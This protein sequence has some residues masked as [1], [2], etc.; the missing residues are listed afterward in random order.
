MA[1]HFSY[2]CPMCDNNV[3]PMLALITRP[4]V[5]C[6]RCGTT[7]NVNRDM[8]IQNWTRNLYLQGALV[9]WVLFT[10]WALT[11]PAPSG[12]KAEPWTLVVGML[13]FGWLPAALAAVPFVFVGLVGGHIMAGRILA[14]IVR[15]EPVPL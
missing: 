5:R 7:V 4:T 9:L 12:P 8:V 2:R 13:L 14:Q 10:L 15:Q 1:V 6:S 3:S 11:S